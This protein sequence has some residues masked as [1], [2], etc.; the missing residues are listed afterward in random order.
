LPAGD[1]DDDNDDG[2]DDGGGYENLKREEINIHRR[3]VTYC[4]HHRRLNLTLH[5]LLRL[6]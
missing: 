1:D 2:N 5:L 6:C 4:W 3:F